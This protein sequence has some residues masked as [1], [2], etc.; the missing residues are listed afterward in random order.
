MPT[1]KETATTAVTLGE[2]VYRVATNVGCTREGTTTSNGSTT[3]LIDSAL[4]QANNYWQGSAVIII[5]TNDYKYNFRKIS[6][7]VQATGTITFSP[8]LS[9]SVP[10]NARYSL[11]KKRY[12]LDVIIQSIN[13]ALMD[14]AELIYTQDLTANETN[15][16]SVGGD[17]LANLCKVE[18]KIGESKWRTLYNWKI[19]VNAWGDQVLLASAPTNATVRLYYTDKHKPIFNDTDT[20]S[21]ILNEKHIDA[22]VYRATANAFQWMKNK[23]N[24]VDAIL[25]NNIQSYEL[26]AAEELRKNP[27]NWGIRRTP[28]FMEVKLG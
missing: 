18:Y 21:P 4:S 27:P 20:L 16:Y 17:I 26:K 1:P 15:E 3:T 23:S 19:G 5:Y 12:P 14:F 25:L 13:D 10:A 9:Y 11:I 24:S 6:S 28:R 7:S 2:I 22:I 8:A